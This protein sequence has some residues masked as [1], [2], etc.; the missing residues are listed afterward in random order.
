MV[1]SSALQEAQARLDVLRQNSSQRSAGSDAG[2]PNA[3]HC[4]PAHLS[5][6]KATLVALM[7]EECAQWRPTGISIQVLKDDPPEDAAR[8]SLTDILIHGELAAAVLR[9][10]CVATARVWWILRATDRQGIG[11][12]EK[13]GVKAQLSGQIGGWRRVRQLLCEGD[14][15]FWVWD[16]EQVWLRSAAKVAAALGIVR[17]AADP[18]AFS[19][20]K[21]FGRIAQVK[22]NLYAIFH[23]TRDE[24]PIARETL[25]DLTGISASSQ[26]S[27]EACAGVQSKTQY[28]LLAEN[29]EDAAWQHGF[30]VFTFTDHLGKHGKAGQR[31]TAR[32]LPNC[33][34][35]PFKQ[36]RYKNRRQRLNRKL[37]D[38]LKQGTTGNGWQ[39]VEQVYY[40]NGVR[41]NG[42]FRGGNGMW[43]MCGQQGSS[44]RVSNLI[45]GEEKYQ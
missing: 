28:A 2:S 24:T 20:Q 13:Q 5:W 23:S 4:L 3:N 29:L 38:L 18:V 30:A 11:R 1:V 27:Y 32:Q 21:L 10:G 39:T 25:R 44:R 45:S 12:F 16:G 42:Y 33:Y 19:I 36:H 22:A 31:W 7:R 15:L 6:G 8:G 43:F 17:I 26:R 34:S 37:V 9:A 14:G 40:T 41:E 35:A